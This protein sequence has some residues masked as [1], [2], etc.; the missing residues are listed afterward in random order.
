MEIE[1]SPHIKRL[2]G[3]GWLRNGNRTGDLSGCRKCGAK[4]RPGSTCKAPAMPNGR[5]RFHGGKATGATT[6]AGIERI[7][8]A[9]TIH[10]RYS[11]EAI[12]ERSAIR[13]LMRDARSFLGHDKR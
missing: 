9:R 3:T 8:E 1:G 11:K 12:R 5:C 10:G 6:A 13:E 4:T 2:P 7:R